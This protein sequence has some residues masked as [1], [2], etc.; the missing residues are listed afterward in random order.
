[1]MFLLFIHYSSS[2]HS[3]VYINTAC[4]NPLLSGFSIFAI[5]SKRLTFIARSLAIYFFF[6]LFSYWHNAAF[7]LYAFELIESYGLK[8]VLWMKYIW[9]F[10]IH[11]IIRNGF[12]CVTFCSSIVIVNIASG[13][14]A[15]IA[16]HD[17]SKLLA[18]FSIH[19]L[20]RSF[21]FNDHLCSEWVHVQRSSV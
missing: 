21:L 7:Y 2:F 1:M 4:N 6:V 12:Q 9:E 18:L 19:C 13:D 14:M 5:D 10:L 20:L 16:W 15:L 3:V 11:F 17:A 8:T